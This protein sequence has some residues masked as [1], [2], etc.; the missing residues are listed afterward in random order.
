MGLPLVRLGLG[1]GLGITSG[2]QARGMVLVGV[3]LF[4]GFLE[5]ESGVVCFGMLDSLPIERLLGLVLLAYSSS[6][7]SGLLSRPALDSRMLLLCPFVGLA[8]ARVWHLSRQNNP[9]RRG[10]MVHGVVGVVVVLVLVRFLM[11]L[12]LLIL[13]WLV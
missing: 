4:A 13:V 9:L 5:S 7:Y 11:R 3:V 1:Q 12:L 8:V 2:E 10:R 6:L